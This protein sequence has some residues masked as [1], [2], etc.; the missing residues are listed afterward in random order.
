MQK[1]E[2]VK[3]DALQA[4][5]VEGNDYLIKENI[6]MLSSELPFQEN[7][8]VPSEDGQYDGSIVGNDFMM[9]SIAQPYPTNDLHYE[10]DNFIVNLLKNPKSTKEDF[11]SRKLEHG[12]LKKE[13]T[14]DKHN[15]YFH[16]DYKNQ[17]TFT[18]DLGVPVPKH[19]KGVFW[20]EYPFH[21]DI[22]LDS[23]Q[24]LCKEDNIEE[25]KAERYGDDV[26]YK[27]DFLLFSFDSDPKYS[28]LDI[29]QR[30]IS[31]G[32]EHKHS[33]LVFHKIGKGEV[34]E[35]WDN[36]GVVGD[37]VVQKMHDG[38]CN[39]NLIQLLRRL[40]ILI[41]KHWVCNAFYSS[42]I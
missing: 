13:I 5:V 15:E 9:D 27:L 1:E 10:S 26:E 7:E 8:L 38:E 2:R 14:H 19:V 35:D 22:V 17:P 37:R 6:T 23:S 29:D 36:H 18:W 32:C 16:L 42:S 4:I 41:P 11:S 39:F 20:N 25:A 28:N 31:L 21:F 12:S 33:S 3:P 34:H 40:K 30:H 24:E